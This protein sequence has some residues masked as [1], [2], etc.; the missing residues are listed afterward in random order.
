MADKDEAHKP[1]LAAA[2]S[3]ACR[4]HYSNAGGGAAA[5]ERHR[6]LALAQPAARKLHPAH[7]AGA[8]VRLGQLTGAAVEQHLALRHRRAAEH[9]HRPAHCPRHRAVL[10][11]GKSPCASGFHSSAAGAG[12]RFCDGHS[13]HADPAGTV[14]HG[15][16]S[17]AGP[18]D[19]RCPLLHH[20]PHRRHPRF[21]QPV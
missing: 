16:R 15:G 4:R 11:P 1:P 6:A 12:H 17:R 8:A 10:L 13:D 9:R 5:L 7:R 20:H 18:P 21:R 14:R 19:L 2:D 3:G